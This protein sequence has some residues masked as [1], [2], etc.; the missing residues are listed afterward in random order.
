MVIS[1]LGMISQNLNHPALADF[2]VPAPLDHL[3]QLGFQRRKAPYPLLDICQAP[4]GYGV[5]GRTR[6]AKVVL[7]TKEGS[8]GIELESQLAS[9]P[10]KRQ[11]FQIGLFIAP[12]VSVASGRSRKEADL[13]VVP[14]G[15]NFYAAFAGRFADI[16]AMQHFSACSSSR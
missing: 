5:R 6:L 1:A 13:L 4:L 7:Q 14:D 10:N 9:M 3:F 2:P 16:D 8:N 12:P 11:P 15:G